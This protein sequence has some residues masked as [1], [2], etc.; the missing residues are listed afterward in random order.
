MEMMTITPSTVVSVSDTLNE[1]AV[2]NMV[3][4]IVADPASWNQA[5]WGKISECGTTLCAAGRTVVQHGYELVYVLRQG[6]SY[7]SCCSLPTEDE[8]HIV[9]EDISETA[10]KILGFDTY[11]LGSIFYYTTTLRY[12]HP[13]VQE[14][15]QRVADITGLEFK[16][17]A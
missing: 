5:S 14:F 3:E 11:Q 2:R 16:I 6:D 4:G 9:N 10:A 1:P 8:E 15:V 7:A 13:T 17:P 12:N